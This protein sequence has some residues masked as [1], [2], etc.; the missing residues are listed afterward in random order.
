[1]SL[2]AA[3]P[4]RTLLQ[5]C[6]QLHDRLNRYRSVAATGAPGPRD[7]KSEHDAIGEA[8]IDRNADLAVSLLLQHYNKT[9]EILRQTLAALK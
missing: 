5:F 4:S 8:V 1:V 6:D 7:W 2:L 9:T 3:S